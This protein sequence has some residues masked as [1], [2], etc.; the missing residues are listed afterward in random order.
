MKN[1]LLTL[2][3]FFCLNLIISQQMPNYQIGTTWTFECIPE[4]PKPGEYFVKFKNYQII[5]TVH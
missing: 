2:F 1:F 5:D 4:S 3:S